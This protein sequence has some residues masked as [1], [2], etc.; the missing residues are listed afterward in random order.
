MNS[1]INLTPMVTII[2]IIVYDTFIKPDDFFM[3]RGFF[4]VSAFLVWL[5]VIHLMKL[6]D[7]T[8]Y[9]L[10]LAG[11]ILFRMR[12]LI[13]FIMVVILGFGFTYSFLNHDD[14]FGALDGFEFIFNVL[15]GFYEPE[16]FSGIY[17]YALY[18]VLVMMNYFFMLT[19]IIALSVTALGEDNSM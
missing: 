18:L 16:D 2:F 11:N 1:Y 13:F 10:R 5:R 3:M 7:S 17:Q 15:L 19:L 12:Y 14:E 9:M 4:S 8:A 6:F